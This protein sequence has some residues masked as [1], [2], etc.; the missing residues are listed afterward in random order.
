M[1]EMY[2]NPVEETMSRE[3]LTALQDVRLKAMVK[4]V[5]EGNEWYRKRFQEAGINPDTF[6]GLADLEKI[7]VMGKLDFR[8]QYPEGM[9][10]VPRD[11]IVEMHQSSGSTGTPVVM[12]YTQADVDQWAECMARCYVLGGM[13]SKDVLQITPGLGLFNGGFGCFHGGR[14][15]GCYIIPAGPGNTVRQI[16]LAKDLHTTAIVAVVSYCTRIMEVLAELKETLP[17]LKVGFFGSETFTEAMKQKIRETLGIDVYDIW[18]MTETGGIGTLGQ[19]CRFH[20]GTHVWEDHYIVEIVDPKTYK[21]VPDG[22]SGE[23]VVTS[24]TRQALPV[25]RFHTGD[26]T[27]VISRNRCSCGRSHIRLA[28]ITGRVDD[29]IIIKGVNIFPSQVEK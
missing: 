6:A 1:T 4:H 3:Q 12:L 15:L 26:L 25:V 9:R 11:Q 7:P 20:C 17:D 13:T 5:Y 18:G 27:H 22:E 10:C 14:K 28:P 24:L 23:L 19:D 29:M 2:F 16:K 8:A 21:A